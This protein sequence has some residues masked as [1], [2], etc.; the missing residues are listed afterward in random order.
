[1]TN[2]NY[3]EL[4]DSSSWVPVLS[5]LVSGNVLDVQYFCEI[6]SDD[7]VQVLVLG[8]GEGGQ[9]PRNQG[10][11]VQ[12]GSGPRILCSC[13]SLRLCNSSFHTTGSFSFGKF[14]KIFARFLVF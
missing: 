10:G 6:S 12:D 14:L 9:V 11:A 8:S 3:L 2:L 5:V 13:F 7:D 1:M 4:E